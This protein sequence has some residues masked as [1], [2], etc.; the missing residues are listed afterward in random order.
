MEEEGW[1]EA[2]RLLFWVMAILALPIVI[3]SVFPL[4][5]GEIV[6]D[7]SI[8]IIVTEM[9]LIGILLT[10]FIYKKARERASL[11]P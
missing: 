4:E 3:M 6:I 5:P 8:Y 2:M 11:R 9:I 10:V 7:W 1:S